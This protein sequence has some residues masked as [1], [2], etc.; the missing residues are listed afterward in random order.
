MIR[1]FT[2]KLVLFLIIF[3]KAKLEKDHSNENII[4]SISIQIGNKVLNEEIIFFG[5]KDYQSF[6]L[7]YKVTSNYIC[8]MQ[9]FYNFLFKKL[10]QYCV[11]EYNINSTSL[12]FIDDEL[13]VFDYY[14]NLSISKNKPKFS[15][16]YP[17]SKK[18]EGKVPQNIRNPIF[19]LKDQLFQT[20]KFRIKNENL[21]VTINI[22]YDNTYNLIPYNYIMISKYIPFI[23]IILALMMIFLGKKNH[24]YK[25]FIFLSIFG[26]SYNLMYIKNVNETLKYN[27]DFYENLF[28]IDNIYEVLG[29]ILNS[30]F[31]IM[32]YYFII[33]LSRGFG[34]LYYS[35]NIVNSQKMYFLLIITYIFIS[36]DPIFEVFTF[37]IFSLSLRE[38]KKLLLNIFILLYCI[39]NINICKKYLENYL[40]VAVVQN[41]NYFF[42]IM[43]KLVFF[44]CLKGILIMHLFFYISTLFLFKKYQQS[45]YYFLIQN[46]YEENL[47]CVHLDLI[48]LFF[49]F[50]KKKFFRIENL[51]DF[52]IIKKLEISKCFI[53]KT[54][55][56]IFIIKMSI[57]NKKPLIILNP[58]KNKLE[59]NMNINYLKIGKI[60]F[61]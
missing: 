22:I 55:N 4:S 48:I 49:I 8:Y 61:D 36:T 15:I 17:S 9:Y 43:K 2:F 7:K 19:I 28:R 24:F 1:I 5:I 52:N 32:Y 34:I 51:E 60:S 50:D 37:Q 10:I 45:S 29:N 47:F 40:I 33:L 14:Y 59:K 27:I 54:Q 44:S 26:I 13:L 53:N 20:M 25:F 57:K 21:N 46:S 16:I 58:Y 12:L 18:L 23:T 38:I 31:Q 56:I 3:K 35:I 42:L 39:I 6:L 41:R 30:F 11:G